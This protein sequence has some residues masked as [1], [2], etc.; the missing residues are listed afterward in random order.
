MADQGMGSGNLTYEAEPTAFVEVMFA[1][2]VQEA[3]DCC[4]LLEEREIPARFERASGFA[5]SLGVPVLVPP[6][7]L[8][9]ASE[10]LAF[11]AEDDDDG[12][13]DFEEDG[14]ED[15]DD[16]DDD[17]FDFDDDD[18]DED[19]DELEDDEED[20]EENSLGGR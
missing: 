11:R 17:E 3:E 7:L 5:S 1:K 12:G 19:D 6:S 10:V 4:V 14:D 15:A 13:D 16:D 20:F 8:I 2:S 9:E 18:D